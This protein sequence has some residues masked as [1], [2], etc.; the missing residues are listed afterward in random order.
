MRYILF[1]LAF[2]VIASPAFAQGQVVFCGYPEEPDMETEIADNYCDIYQRQMAYGESDQRF[3]EQIEQR[4]ENYNA[5]RAQAIQ[6]YKTDMEALN[7]R[8]GTGDYNN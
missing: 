4:R 1:A 8:R 7:A 6:R 5:P 3:K 2:L